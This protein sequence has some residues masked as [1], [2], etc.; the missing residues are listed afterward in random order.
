MVREGPGPFLASFLRVLRGDL[1]SHLQNLAFGP[2]STSPSEYQGP[3]LRPLYIAHRHKDAL[4][5]IPAPLRMLMR[6]QGRQEFTG[7]VHYGRYGLPEMGV[8]I[9]RLEG[10]NMGLGSRVVEDPRRGFNGI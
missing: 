4:E 9:S 2:G 6:G 3:D 8:Y 5:P 1:G 7:A 10:R